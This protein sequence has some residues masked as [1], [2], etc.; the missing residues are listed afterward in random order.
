MPAVDCCVQQRQSS[1]LSLSWRWS[2]VT[3][4][5]CT[6]VGHCHPLRPLISSSPPLPSLLPSPSARPP[7]LSP[8]PLPYCP[9]PLRCLRA[10]L[11]V[12]TI[13]LAALALA[14]FVTRQPRHHHHHPRCRLRRRH[15]RR[16]CPRRRCS[17]VTLVAI[18]LAAVAIALFVAR[19]PC[20]RR[21]PSRHRPRPLRPPP[22]SLPSPS[23][24]PPSPSLSLPSSSA[25]CSRCSLSPTIVVMWLP[26]QR[27]LA[28]HRPPL[29]VPSLVDCCSPSVAIALVAVTL[30]PTSLPLLLYQLPSPSSSH[31]TQ[32]CQRHGP[33]RPRPL[34]RPALIA[35]TITLAILALFV[36]AI[37]IRRTLSSFVVAHRRGRWSCGRL[38]DALLPATAHLRRS[39]HWLIVMIIRRFQTQGIH[40]W[41]GRGGHIEEPV[42]SALLSAG[43]CV[44][45]EPTGEPTCGDLMVGEAGTRMSYHSSGGALIASCRQL[46]RRLAMVGC[47][48]L[49]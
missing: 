49:C 18:A 4:V 47:C 37:P 24:F 11:I 28:S 7:P 2:W 20:R 12:I 5:W 44:H 36:A 23:P 46:L 43:R 6:K 48:V 38:V 31:T 45:G 41:G 10:T 35:A 9:R 32:H 27:S 34:G 21:H 40:Q 22:T 8:S 15:C 33:C 26:R 17:P 13:A 19:Q 29:S 16:H 1:S 14:L 30:L 25:A 39:R 3:V 42:K